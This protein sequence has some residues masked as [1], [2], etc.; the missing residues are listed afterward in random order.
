MDSSW[1]LLCLCLGVVGSQTVNS[2]PISLQ[3]QPPKPVWSL[4]YKGEWTSNVASAFGVYTTSQGL[5][6]FNCESAGN[7]TAVSVCGLYLHNGQWNDDTIYRVKF[8]EVA[9]DAVSSRIMLSGN[10]SL[11]D[12][13]NHSLQSFPVDGALRYSGQSP[14]RLFGNV[15]C[16]ENTRFFLTMSEM[17]TAS[18]TAPL[19]TYYGVVLVSALLQL[20]AYLSLWRDCKVSQRLCVQL[21]AT[22]LTMQFATDIWICL[23]HLLLLLY[24]A[25]QYAPVMILCNVAACLVMIFMVF[26]EVWRQG[27]TGDSFCNFVAGYFANAFII[28]PIAEFIMLFNYRINVVFLSF[29]YLPQI[30]S[31]A[32]NR[33][34][35]KIG[36][37]TYGPL[38]A[39]RLLLIVTST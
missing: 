16:G 33:E 1:L 36:Y 8:T 34:P 32:Q 30:Y 10:G 21:S 19:E 14:V 12:R 22:S 27:D 38:G 13:I 26:R 2:S 28:V 20:V 18:M 17:T 29:F 25:A 9:F 7:S 11:E 39:S 4:R 3:F 5:C 6:Y 24:P 37:L 15:V 23:W 35:N 31:N